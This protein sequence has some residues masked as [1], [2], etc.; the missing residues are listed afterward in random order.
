[1]PLEFADIDDLQVIFCEDIL[2]VKP[3]LRHSRTAEG[4]VFSEDFVLSFQ[5]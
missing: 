5:I 4:P 3:F 1:M 2:K